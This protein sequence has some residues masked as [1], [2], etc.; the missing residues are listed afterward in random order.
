MAL[1]VE[2]I[3]REQTNTFMVRF[4]KS[5]KSGLYLSSFCLALRSAFLSLLL[6]SLLLQFL[7]FSFSSLLLGDNDKL[8]KQIRRFIFTRHLSSCHL[9]IGAKNLQDRMLTSYTQPRLAQPRPMIEY[10]VESHATPLCWIIWARQESKRG[11][12]TCNLQCCQPLSQ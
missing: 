6:M 2:K 8:K 4:N 9:E 10:P 5:S 7:A 1:K 12:T 11:L 3:P